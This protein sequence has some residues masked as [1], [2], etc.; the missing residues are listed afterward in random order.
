MLN[1]PTVLAETAA[2]GDQQPF[3]DSASSNETLAAIQN[4]TT[5][6]LGQGRQRITKADFFNPTAGIKSA[7]D[8]S[9]DPFSALDPMWSL[10]G[11]KS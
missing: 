10:G 9:D 11:G 7:V 8:K 6:E 3:D 4:P 1:T 5:F 2:H